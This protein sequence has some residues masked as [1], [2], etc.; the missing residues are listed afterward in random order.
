[1]FLCS[2]LITT[3]GQTDSLHWAD[4]RPREVANVLWA[5]GKLRVED[6]FLLSEACT[7]I[8]QRVHAFKAQEV[9]NSV[10]AMAFC[11]NYLYLLFK[12]LRAFRQARLKDDDLWLH[13]DTLRV[14]LDFSSQTFF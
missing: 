4:F 7:Q 13:R 9:S 2:R 12:R 11:T 3:T 10:Y 8:S 1:M 6:I 14:L 5:L